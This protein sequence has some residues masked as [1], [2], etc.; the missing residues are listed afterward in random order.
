MPAEWIVEVIMEAMRRHGKLVI[1]NSDQGSQFTSDLYINLLKDN[2]IDINMD[3]KGRAVDNIFIKRLWRSLKYEH[4]YRYAHKDGNELYSGL[5]KYFEF[6]NLARLLQSLDYETPAS[7]Y[8]QYAALFVCQL[9]GGDCA[10]SSNPHQ[11][12]HKAPLWRA[13]DALAPNF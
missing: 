1:V 4:I 6:Y 8:M 7:C 5:N 9:G 11:P 2:E 13:N 12:M 10:L 3:G